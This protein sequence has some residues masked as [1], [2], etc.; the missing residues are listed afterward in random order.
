MGRRLLNVLFAALIISGLV[1]YFAG[2]GDRRAMAC[3]CTRPGSPGEELQRVGAVFS[4]EVIRAD[5]EGIEFKVE[6]IWKGPRAKKVTMNHELSDCTYVFVLGKKYLVYAYGKGS[7]STSIC[8]RTRRLD[9]ASDD[10]KELG[11]GAEP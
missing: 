11:E 4:G 10:L 9:N 5:R 1:L 3:D 8:T 2:L 7:F 6:K